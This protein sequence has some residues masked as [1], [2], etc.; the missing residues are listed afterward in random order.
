MKHTPTQQEIA[1]ILAEARTAG[2]ERLTGT[3]EERR[4]QFRKLRQDDY[5]QEGISDDKDYRLAR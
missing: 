2:S 5:T 3:R 1:A 4:D